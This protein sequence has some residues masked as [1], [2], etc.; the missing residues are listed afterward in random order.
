MVAANIANLKEGRPGAQ[1]RPIG[2]VAKMTGR[3]HRPQIK[4]KKSTIG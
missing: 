2:L 3:R 1:T 4:L